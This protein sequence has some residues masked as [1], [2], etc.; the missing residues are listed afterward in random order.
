MSTLS[1][2]GKEP[3]TGSRPDGVGPEPAVRYLKAE[4]VYVGLALTFGLLFLLQTAPFQAPDEE[5]H[6]RRAFSFAEGRI[7][8]IKQ[9]NATGDFQP[10]GISDFCAPYSQIAYHP[11]QKTSYEIIRDSGSASIDPGDREFVAFSNATVHPPLVYIPQAL[12]IFLARLATPSVMVG[13]YA[14]RLVNLLAV[15]AV[16]FLAIRVAP[17]GKWA[18]VC[19]GLTPITLFLSASLSSDGLTDAFAFLLVALT[20]ACALGPAGRVSN[21]LLTAL[22]LSAVSVGLSKQAY[23]LL[24]LCYLMIPGERLGSRRRYWGGLAL[25]MGATFLAVAA[26]AM[27]VRGIYSPSDTNKGIDPASQLR[28]MLMDPIEF[29]RVLWRTTAWAG[30]IAEQF[31]AWLGQLDTR[32]PRWIA[33]V[34]YVLLAVVC[35]REFGPRSG[36]SAREALVAA[37]VVVLVSLTL[38]VV[39]HATWDPVGG[40]LVAV[41]GRYFLPIGPLAGIAVGRALGSIP[42]ELRRARAAVPAGAVLCAC[43]VLSA[44]FWRLHERYFVDSPS[45]AAER[46]FAKAKAIDLKRGPRQESVELLEE[47][48]RTYPYHVASNFVLGE[49]LLETDPA[50]GI[51]HLRT[52]LR[53]SPENAEACAKTGEVLLRAGQFAEAEKMFREAARFAPDNVEVRKSLTVAS[54][55]HEQL[56]RALERIS[57]TLPGLARRDHVEERYAGTPKH[58]L[59]MKAD[60]G[61]ILSESG[62]PAFNP[63]FVWRCPPP[64]GEEIRFGDADGAHSTNTRRA[65]F[66]ACVAAPA[67]RRFFVFPPPRNAVA[68]VDGEVSWYYQVPLSELN[69]DERRK[70]DEYRSRLGLT[71]PL[72]KLPD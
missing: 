60:R 47:A 57:A 22:T 20:L 59:Y 61:P 8:C 18:F 37:G 43:V 12:G 38:L 17:V 56:N 49:Y 58:G 9:G 24:P 31:V 10:R 52:V 39:V 1:A 70:E 15:T 62:Q 51:E 27:V 50:R 34:E 69:E 2:P 48:L 41:Q 7:V 66:Y 67:P 3:A 72:S 44:T 71:F 4:W 25:V 40:P 19:F 35:A 6:F 65:P 68:L 14:G 26:W 46:L 23:F 5:S 21:R 13:F 29:V 54:Q 28:L 53:L 55:S 42:I 11:E 30:M 45:A 64:S 33:P 36:L 16:T 63:G 32:L